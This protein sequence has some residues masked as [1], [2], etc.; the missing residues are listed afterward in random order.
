MPNFLI[1]LTISIASISFFVLY[2]QIGKVNSGAKRSNVHPSMLRL[3]DEER[4]EYEI[5]LRE[6][7]NILRP[8]YD[9]NG[10]LLPLYHNE[11]RYPAL[12]NAIRKER[13]APISNEMIDKVREHIG[14]DADLEHVIFDLELTGDALTTI[15]N[16]FEVGFITPPSEYYIVPPAEEELSRNESGEQNTEVASEEIAGT[17][18]DTNTSSS[19]REATESSSANVFIAL[20]NMYLNPQNLITKYNIELNKDY[21]SLVDSGSM[22]SKAKYMIWKARKN[23]E[24]LDENKSLKR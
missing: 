3:Q 13:C 1:A 10:N 16:Y 12:T 17:R 6:Q 24:R 19:S 9:M 2:S 7:Q 18:S 20:N 15:D 14:V 11:N 5:H 4:Q 23:V 22:K 8:E 21:E